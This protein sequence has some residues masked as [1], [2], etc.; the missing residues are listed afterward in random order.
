MYRKVE[1]T[2]HMTM[3]EASERYPDNF[4]LMQ[5]DNRDIY[6][7]AGIVLY[8]GDNYNEL[9]SLMMKFDVPLGLV[10]EGLNHQRSLGGI[11]NSNTPP[12]EVRRLRLHCIRK[13]LNY[14]PAI[15]AKKISAY[16][17]NTAI[18]GSGR[19]KMRRDLRSFIWKRSILR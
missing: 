2:P 11:A 19:K 6:D 18:P 12:I 3:H 13:D 10:V 7:P 15:K 8:L 9:F 14:S 1:D 4:I 16:T 17:K 5:M